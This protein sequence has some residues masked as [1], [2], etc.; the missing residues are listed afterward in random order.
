MGVLIAAVAGLVFWIVAWALGAKS[1]DAFLI[2]VAIFLIAVAG[3]MISPYL[4]G[5]RRDA[6]ERS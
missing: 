3:R 2:T 5:N 4:P 1:I 6:V